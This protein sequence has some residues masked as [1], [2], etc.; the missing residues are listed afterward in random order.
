MYRTVRYF[1][2]K[3]S[4][5]LSRLTPLQLVRAGAWLG[6]LWY[7]VLRIRKSVVMANISR[8]FPERPTFQ[9]RRIARRF[10]ESFST[11]ILE[12]L[13]IHSRDQG[14]AQPSVRGIEH[15]LDAMEKGRGIVAVTAHMGN[16]DLLACS[17]ALIK[18]PLGI[19]SKRLTNRAVN[20]FWMNTRANCGVRIFE[21]GSPAAAVFRWL[22]HGKVLGVVVDQRLSQAKGGVLVPFLG[23][24]VWTSVAAA[25]LAL[26]TGATLLPVM[27]HRNADGCHEIVF[28]REISLVDVQ[29]RKRG[30]I[31]LMTQIH[32][33]LEQWIVAFPEEWMWIHRRFKD[34]VK[35]ASNSDMD[36]GAEGTFH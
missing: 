15:Y 9:Q 24:R 27:I 2:L 3:V 1:L 26:R 16:F 28:E 20:D 5:F 22:T 17:Q 4:V 36:S 25:D 32:S 10:Y 30:R 29:G 31:E 18:V 13:A 6:V 23:Y 11:S 7:Y 19:V 12:F 14:I 35:I 34:A 33:V 21:E 8:V